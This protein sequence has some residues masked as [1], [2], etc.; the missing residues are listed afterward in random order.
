MFVLIIALCIQFVFSPFKE[1][2]NILNNC[3]GASLFVSTMTFTSGL[4]FNEKST[5]ST[6]RLITAIIIIASNMCLLMGLIAIMLIYLYKYV[7]YFIINLIYFIFRYF[8]TKLV[9]SD[10]VD[11]NDHFLN[12]IRKFVKS[13]YR[14]AKPKVLE[15][16]RFYKK[17]ETNDSDCES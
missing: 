7:E 11:E 14:K 10:K 17:A 2:F 15:I 6:A 8:K 3:E 12:V 9:L 1:E 5:V 4:L 13:S 16:V